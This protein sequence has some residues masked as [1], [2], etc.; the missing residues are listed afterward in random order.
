MNFQKDV[1][2]RSFQ[3]PVLVDFWAEWCGPCR[4]LGPTLEQLAEEQ[5]ERWE[6]VKIDTEEFQDLAVQYNIRSIPNVK[7]F[8]KGEI[9][10]EFAGALSKSMVE[11][12]LDENLPDP[13]VESL[14]QILESQVRIPDEIMIAL[15][16]DFC[17]KNPTSLEARLALAKHLIFLEKDKAL[18]LVQEIHLGNPL[19]DDAEDIR[20]LHR[21]FS[22]DFNPEIEI[23]KLL[24]VAKEASMR[25]DFK[26]AI[27]KIIDASAIDKNYLQDMPRKTAIAFFRTWGNQHELTKSYRWKFDMVLY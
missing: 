20:N 24:Q 15:L 9:A 14:H 1:L 19:F 12:W 21:F 6:L 17:S 5:K 4:V 13:S 27:E 8:Y 7:L 22:Q 25:S 16:K 10:A 18:E 2:D 3:K 23:E 26:K 11:K